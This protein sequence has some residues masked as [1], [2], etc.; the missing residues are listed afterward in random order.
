MYLQ[1]GGRDRRNCFG[2]GFILVLLLAFLLPAVQKMWDAA[3]RVSCQLNLYHYGLAIHN[4]H[5]VNGRFPP[6]T[7]PNAALAPEQ[8]LSFHVVLIP[9]VEASPLY[10]QLAKTEPW[11]SPTNVGVVGDGR[12][13]VFQCPAWVGAAKDVPL[14]GH[15]AITNYVGVAGVGADAATLSLGAPG[16]GIFGYDCSV[17][18]KDVKDGSDNTALLFETAHDVGPWMRGGPATVR[19]VDAAAP[20]GGT[21][22]RQTWTFQKRADGFNVVLANGAV[23]HTSPDISPEVLAALATIAGGEKIGDDW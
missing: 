20:F 3:A 19:G 16:C 4:Y 11:D 21:H 8:R 9:F 1:F 12:F 2:C 5:D 14:T 22:F 23:R 13:K 10:Y 17:K 18:G 15:L 6:G 7:I